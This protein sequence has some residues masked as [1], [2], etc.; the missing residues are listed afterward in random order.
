MPVGAAFTPPVRQDELDLRAYARGFWRRKW[1]LAGCTIV[2]VGLAAAL[3][4]VQ[5]RSYSARAEILLEAS[6]TTTGLTSGAPSELS[7]VDVETQMQL[8][9]STSVRE[10]VARDLHTS[11]SH[12]PEVS[13]SEIGT[14]NVIQIACSS[15]SPAKAAQV[16]NLYAQDYLSVRSLQDSQA[17]LTAATELE[18]KV[19]DLTNELNSLEAHQGSS[20]TQVSALASQLAAYQSQYEQL[21]VDA[22]LASGSAELVTRATQPSR[23][24]SPR[25]VLD[26]LVGLVIGLGAGVG[27]SLLLERLDDRIRDNKDLESVSGQPVL[28]V[29][30]LVRSW[31]RREEAYVASIHEPQ[32]EAAEAYRKLRTALRFADLDGGR[33]VVQVTSPS[34]DEGKST[35]SA[36]LAVALAMAGIEVLLVDADLRRP[37]LDQFFGRP[38]VV[39][40]TTV[41]IGD[42]TVDEAVQSTE[43]ANLTFLASGEIPPNPAEVLSSD[44]M[45]ALIDQLRRRFAMVV[46]DGP[47]VLPVTDAVALATGTDGTILVARSGVTRQDDVTNALHLLGQVGGHVLGTVFNAVRSNSRGYGGYNYSSYPPVHGG[48]VTSAS[49]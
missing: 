33:Q 43:V 8:V 10:A 14:T 46:I 22:S 35:T 18:P 39:G 24:S 15:N 34:Q 48:R 31:S 2:G 45:S 3:V 30:P 23:P 27:L 21:Q 5:P 16:A 37:R 13:V 11:L 36:N 42:A 17:F 28:G 7:T 40:L 38:A 47:P 4:E 49:A 32:G 6:P 25:P 1:V 20:A 41:L 19:A 44:R 9:T 26:V 29:I 12:A